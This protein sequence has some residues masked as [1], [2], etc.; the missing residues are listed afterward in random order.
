[1]GLVYMHFDCGQ[2]QMLTIRCMQSEIS[3][4]SCADRSIPKAVISDVVILPPNNLSINLDIDKLEP[5]SLSILKLDDI[6]DPTY[7]LLNSATS[8]LV[9][10][11]PWRFPSSVSLWSKM[12]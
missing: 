10:S 8:V 9:K 11:E 2:Q 6:H 4:T 7:P 3:R 12:K 5:Q 1:M